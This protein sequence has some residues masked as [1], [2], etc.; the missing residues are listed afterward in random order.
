[1]PV[2][3]RL[4]VN[5]NICPSSSRCKNK[6]KAANIEKVEDNCITD[7]MNY[8]SDTFNLDSKNQ[9]QPREGSR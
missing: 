3:E 2:Q 1:M 6:Y 8:I 7:S 9:V 4:K 5:E